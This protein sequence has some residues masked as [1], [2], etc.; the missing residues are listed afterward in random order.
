MQ[1][2]WTELATLYVTVSQA[3]VS[4]LAD[5]VIQFA[6]Y[7]CWERQLL[8]HGLLDGQLAY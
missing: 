2:F 5:P 3:Q 7:A 8:D 1:L 4:P 6:E